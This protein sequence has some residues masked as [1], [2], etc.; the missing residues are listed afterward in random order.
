MK[1]TNKRKKLFVHRRIQGKAIS[2]V[3]VY[4]AGYHVILW[5]L[6]FFL[7]LCRNYGGFSQGESVQDFADLYSNFIQSQIPM[8]LCGLLIL[9]FLMWDVLK[10][11]HRCVG[12]VV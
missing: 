11:T 2:Y 3:F 7:Q 8:L 9:P 6:M 4:W 10:T 12:P 5:I 1:S